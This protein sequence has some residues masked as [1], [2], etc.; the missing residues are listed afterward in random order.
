MGVKVN[1]DKG[2]IFEGPTVSGFAAL[3]EVVDLVDKDTLV[4]LASVGRN[5]F[6]RREPPISVETAVER[7][8]LL[9]EDEKRRSGRRRSAAPTEERTEDVV[10]AAA[11]SDDEK[12]EEN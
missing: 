6:A 4:R 8:W 1:I 7:G 2:V 11:D 5:V 10:E 9:L 12:R 3:G